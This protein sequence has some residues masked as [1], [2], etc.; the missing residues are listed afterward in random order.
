ML[1][2]ARLWP[3]GTLALMVLTYAGFYL[4]RS[5]FSVAK[6]YLIAAYPEA[7][8][9]STLGEIASIGTLLYAAGKFLGG[10]LADSLSGKRTLVLGGIGAVLFTLLFGLGGPPI[11][12]LAW[13]ANRFVQSFGWGGMV[14]ITSRW[15][16]GDANGR[17]MAFISLSYLFGD[18]AARKLLS[19]WFD[20]GSAWSQVYIFSAVGLALI[21]VPTI[22]LLRD[23]P[24]Q[25]G[26]P[27]PPARRETAFSAEAPRTDLRW[28]ARLIPLL[29]SPTFLTVCVL[30][31][32]F[33][34]MRETFNE[35]T[36]TYLHEVGGLSKSAAGDASSYFPLFGGLSVIA[37]GFLSDRFRRW[38]NVAIIGTG[39]ALSAL[40]LVWLS[41]LPAGHAFQ[42]PVIA[43]IAFTLIG[44]Y[45]LLAGAMSLDFGGKDASGTAAGWIDG[46]GYIGGILAGKWVADLATARG[47]SAAFAVLAGMATLCAVIT[48]GYGALRYR[49]L[50]ALKAQENVA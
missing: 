49:Q 48:L 17:A 33:T 34:F 11:F 9:K 8:T 3:A 22:L 31:F 38:G 36:P 12:L 23:N 37:V 28:W 15:F 13:S 27:E 20:A 7:V 19:T 40:G 39:L 41:R 30:S 42:T 4:C 24:G 2:R 32:G 29:S 5:N 14:K 18:F 1:T 26:L 50:L 16:P 43:A 46:V 10:S 25:V 21:L 35:W 6:P 44:P 47:W 45:S